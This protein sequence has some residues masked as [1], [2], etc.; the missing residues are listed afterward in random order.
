MTGRSSC[1]SLLPSVLPSFLP[2]F[3]RLVQLQKNKCL[4]AQHKYRMF[5]NIYDFFFRYKEFLLSRR[6]YRNTFHMMFI[7]LEDHKYIPA[8]FRIHPQDDSKAK[9]RYVLT[10]IH[11]HKCISPFQPNNRLLYSGKF[12]IQYF[13]Y[14]EISIILF[15]NILITQN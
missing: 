5:H 13:Q 2:L 8:K 14:L 15:I 9:A 7:C 11:I 1:P 4:I 10:H 12:T 6:Q 3:F